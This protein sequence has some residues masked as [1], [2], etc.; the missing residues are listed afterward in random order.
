MEPAV[1]NFAMDLEE[2]FEID[3]RTVMYHR[4]NGCKACHL[5]PHLVDNLTL[6]DMRKHLLLQG[7]TAKVAELDELIAR[8]KPVFV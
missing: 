8:K 6:F 5:G 4:R 7:E 2:M 3:L 1:R